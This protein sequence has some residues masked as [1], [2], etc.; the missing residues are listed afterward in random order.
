MDDTKTFDEFKAKVLKFYPRATGDQIHTIQD[1]DLV[2]GHYACVGI[3]NGTDLGEYYRR[4][5][6]I[7]RYLIDKNRMSEQE[8]SRYFFQGFQAQLEAPVR[9]RL[10]QKFI[11]H[12]SANPYELGDIYKAV[13]YVLMGAASMSLVLPPSP[14]PNPVPVTP[15]P[16][17]ANAVK[18]EALTA[19][20]ASLGE[21]FKVAIQSQQAGSSP[22]S[23]GAIA[24]G[25][26]APRGSAC[27]FCGS[28]GHFI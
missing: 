9:Q 24:S 22:R 7:T 26:G 23:T 5:I 16:P 2:I 3:S 6:I 21:M 11:D 25:I 19:M 28:P 12:F 17:N 15:S 27:N 20:V 13:N 1:L 4:F 18:I 10:Q 14:T 8:Q